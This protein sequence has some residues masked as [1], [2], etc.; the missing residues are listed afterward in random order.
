M[1]SKLP[2]PDDAVIVDSQAI[3]EQNSYSVV[4]ATSEEVAALLEMFK[5]TMSGWIASEVFERGGGYSI[6]GNDSDVYVHI[7]FNPH[8]LQ[9]FT[10]YEGKTGVSIICQ[11]LE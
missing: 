6:D 5:D 1:R 2:F 8:M 7:E 10:E 4:Y 11:A 3:P 9:N